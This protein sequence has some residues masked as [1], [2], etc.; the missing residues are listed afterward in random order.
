MGREANATENQGDILIVMSF[1]VNIS[2]NLGDQQIIYF[3]AS[4][5]GKFD[6]SEILSDH[7]FLHV[8]VPFYH[9]NLK[10]RQKKPILG[11]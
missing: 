6:Q 8:N 10:E 7:L 1:T 4:R 2:L 5:V 3:F 11:F 9:F